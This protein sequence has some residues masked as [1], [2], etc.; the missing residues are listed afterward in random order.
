MGKNGKLFE[1]GKIGNVQVKNRTVMSSMGLGYAEPG[2]RPGERTR[3]YYEERCKGG[4]GMINVEATAVDDI[5]GDVGALH[6]S[7]ANDKYVA[8][9]ELLVD[10]IHKYDVVTFIQLYS[11]GCMSRPMPDGTWAMSEVPFKPGGVSHHKMT[12]D[13]IHQMQQKF[14]DAAVRAQKAGFDGVELHAAHN[15][16]LMQSLTPYYNNRD[17][18]YGGSTENRA[19][20]ITET[21]E[22]IHKRL[23]RNFPVNVRFAGDQFTDTEGFYGLE[24]G[25]KYAKLFEQAGASA[26]NISNGSS[27]NP[28]GNC[29]PFSYR[30]GWK[31]HVAK[32]I[33][34]AVSIPVLATNTVK[35]LAWAEQTLADG[36]CDFIVL[37][38]STIC[39]PYAVKKFENDD[40]LGTRKCIGCM[41]CRERLGADMPIYC[42]CNPRVGLEYLFPREFTQDGNGRQVVVIGGGPAGMESAIVMASRGFKVTLFEKENQLGGSMNL[43]DK[44]PFKD[45]ITRFTETLAEE[46]RRLG[47]NV[48][49]GHE[50]STEDVAALKPE[51]I[52]LAAGA[53]PIVPNM[54]GVHNA[55][56]TTSH[57]VITNK[58]KV[59]GKVA[60][61]GSGMTGLECAEKLVEENCQ[62]T[63]VEMQSFVGPGMFQIIVDDTMSRINP[64]HPEIYLKHAMQ[65]V[66]D[67]GVLVKDVTTGEEKELEADYVVLSLGVKPRKELLDKFSGITE[68]IITV[69]D[70][71]KGGRIPQAIRYSFFRTIDFL[72]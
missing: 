26:V 32:A 50:P 38:R 28:N 25:V 2:G 7:L 44:A 72:K 15:Y 70:N 69:G 20:M 41:F 18:E 71:T 22:L 4:I 30:A 52:I 12:V 24:E 51:G 10:T 47:I 56:V 14:V 36:V 17:D 1:P 27:F 39:D 31:A 23:G 61:I 29:E 64:S 42:A 66:T 58:F 9:F 67:K 21:I 40:I 3:K 68:N 8:D 13:E 53:A 19:R 34:E 6:P 37:G 57:D 35:D 16:L 60:I 5:H 45:K 11:N 33:K 55:N 46:V 49:L 48:V 62:L 65:A 43:A 63:I 54:P 59:S